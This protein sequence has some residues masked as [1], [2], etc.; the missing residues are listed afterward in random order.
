MRTNKIVSIILIIGI[1]LSIASCST[2]NE[3]ARCGK[4]ED[5]TELFL[6]DKSVHPNADGKYYCSTCYRYVFSA[7]SIPTVLVDN[8]AEDEET[9]LRIV[10]TFFEAFSDSK[11]N[12]MKQYCSLNCTSQYFH[13]DDVY[14][15]KWAKLVEVGDHE[16]YDSAQGVRF[17]KVFVT[18]DY[19][20][21]EDSSI[22]GGTRTSFWVVLLQD[23]GG[24]WSIHEFNTGG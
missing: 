1:V 17:C 8:E 23:A 3:C 7:T 13:D 15:L 19:E 9:V 14:G 16:F 22:Y 12:V 10:N 2:K 6:F 21:S 11:Y 18:V 20:A 5:E 24:K 4:T